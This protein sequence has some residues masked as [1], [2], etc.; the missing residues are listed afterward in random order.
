M[1]VLRLVE[2]SKRDTVQILSALLARA[3]R[4]E[5]IGVAVC[6]ASRPGVEHCAFTGPYKASPERAVNA[7]MR[8]A[9]MMTRS[10]VDATKPLT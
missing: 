6:F 5:V 4:G 3:A 8:M 7:G 1:V 10:Q 2:R 9:W